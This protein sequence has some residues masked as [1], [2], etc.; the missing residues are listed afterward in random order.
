M[1]KPSFRDSPIRLAVRSATGGRWSGQDQPFSSGLW[2][3]AAAVASGGSQ[4]LGVNRYRIYSASGAISQVTV[5]AALVAGRAYQF[6]MT[7][8]TPVLGTQVQVGDA[9]ANVDDFVSS[10]AGTRAVSFVADGTA[11]TLK[12]PYVGSAGQPTDVVVKNVAVTDITATALN[13]TSQPQARSIVAGST[14][15]FSV[16]VA[17]PFTAIFYR[18]EASTN[19]GGFWFGYSGGSV[20]N[21]PTGSTLTTPT[22]ATVDNGMMFRCRVRMGNTN[23]A[24]G[25]IYSDVATLTVTAA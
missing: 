6:Q 16:T 13:I 7:F 3:H 2:N 25:Q 19:G 14:T 5:P 24:T 21:T 15:T 23:N 22:M 11:A 12:R 10:L 9:G 1:P 17:A 18:W 8:E 4:I 20:T